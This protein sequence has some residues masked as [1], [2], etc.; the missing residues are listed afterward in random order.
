M[1]T[2]GPHLG[3]VGQVDRVV[4]H[5]YP[6]PGQVEEAGMEEEEEW[7]EAWASWEAQ[8]DQ[9]VAS[10]D[11]GHLSAR[12][13]ML[14]HTI[15]LALQEC[16]ALEVAVE[17]VVGEEEEVVDSPLEAHHNSICPPTSVHPCTQ[18]LDSTQCCL[19]EA[20]EVL[21]EGDHPTL[22]LACLHSS[23]MD[24]ADTPSTALHYLVV[25]APEG[26]HMAP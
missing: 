13:P 3:L 10:L 18:G 14:D 24:K 11:G 17:V 20:W 16:L 19:Q 12:H 6:V 22:D 7:V 5:S 26:P 2:L 23:S 9:A 25:E 15:S 4:L 1:M 8:E 21:G